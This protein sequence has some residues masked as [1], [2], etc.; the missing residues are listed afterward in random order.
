MDNKPVSIGTISVTKGY[1]TSVVLL[2]VISVIITNVFIGVVGWKLDFINLIGLAMCVCCGVGALIVVLA[3]IYS[4]ETREDGFQRLEE[5]SEW[6]AQ[7]IEVFCSLYL[8]DKEGD[9][10]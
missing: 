5:W 4:L 9:R 6:L 7:H 2:A 1:L 10:Q 3:I 8:N